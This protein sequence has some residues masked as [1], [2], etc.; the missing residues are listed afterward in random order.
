MLAVFFKKEK[1]TKTTTKNPNKTNTT[2]L[3]SAASFQSFIYSV[4]DK[5][6][7]PVTCVCVFC[8]FYS[9][10]PMT[11]DFHRHEKPVDGLVQ[12]KVI[13]VCCMGNKYFSDVLL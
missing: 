3:G 4:G 5:I 9:I 10:F 1:T 11:L 12:Y 13:A 7:A 8:F 6:L 2:S